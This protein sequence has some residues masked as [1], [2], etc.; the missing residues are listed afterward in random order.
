[1]DA[2]ADLHDLLVDTS[3]MGYTFT[4]DKWRN[5]VNSDTRVIHK[6]PDDPLHKKLMGGKSLD[7]I[8][9]PV[10]KD[11]IDRLLIHTV[12]PVADAAVREV[13]GIWKNENVKDEA[14]CRP[15]SIVQQL[16][17][18]EPSYGEDRDLLIKKIKNIYRTWNAE[19]HENA[20][21]K[22]SNAYIEKCYREFRSLMPTT[23]LW[24]LHQEME[25]LISPSPTAWDLLKASVTYF[26]YP[27]KPFTWRMAG[28]EL[29]FIK[30][31]SIGEARTITPFFYANMK[32]KSIKRC[33]TKSHQLISSP[34]FE[35]SA[36]PSLRWPARKST[37]FHSASRVK[38]NQAKSE[39]PLWNPG[40]RIGA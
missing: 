3:K 28:K 12:M 16:T 36:L 20:K 14:L 34:T 31:W 30:A 26:K 9:S 38:T 1:M 18:M 8:Q 39:G 21:S 32:P 7:S 23:G 22:N 25:I 40:A 11:A 27:N 19:L 5:F 24:N 15:Y 6:Y 37:A 33:D 2:L 35:I 4:K 29:G 10:P 17:E 13:K